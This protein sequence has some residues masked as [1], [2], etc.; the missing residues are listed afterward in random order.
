MRSTQYMHSQVAESWPAWEGK[1]FP[2]EPEKTI[3]DIFHNRETE[4][5]KEDQAKT[6]CS[7]N[8]THFWTT[9]NQTQQLR[10]TT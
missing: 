10:N 3:M 1:K 6:S 2:K 9:T 8:L 5:G 7:Q 4:F